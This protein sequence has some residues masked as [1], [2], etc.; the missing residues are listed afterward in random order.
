[1]LVLW[2]NRLQAVHTPIPGLTLDR[3]EVMDE[4]AAPPVLNISNTTVASAKPKK[5]KEPK[6]EEVKPTEE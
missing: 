6:T 5:E 1:M 2:E 3:I 4:P